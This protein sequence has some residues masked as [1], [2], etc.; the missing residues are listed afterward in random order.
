[1]TGPETEV[2]S[3]IRSMRGRAGRQKAQESF[4]HIEAFSYGKAA[5]GGEV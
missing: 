3:P 4:F 5:P 1:M 2:I